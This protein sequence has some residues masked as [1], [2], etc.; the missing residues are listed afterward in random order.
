LE[1]LAVSSISPR[2]GQSWS[3][4][5]IESFLNNSSPPNDRE[6]LIFGVGLIPL[7]GEESQHIKSGFF[8]NSSRWEDSSKNKSHLGSDILFY[9]KDPLDSILVGAPDL[10]SND[11]EGS[12]FQPIFPTDEFEEDESDYDCSRLYF[13]F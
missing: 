7:I 9:E 12:I 10:L 11:H 8:I 3:E 2:R 1:D 13:L 5:T 4:G 6:I